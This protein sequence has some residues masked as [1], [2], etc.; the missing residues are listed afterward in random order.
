MT[1]AVPAALGPMMLSGL[2]WHPQPSSPPAPAHLLSSLGLDEAWPVILLPKDCSLH[3]REETARPYQISASCSKAQMAVKTY[4][5]YPELEGYP[6]V[7]PG[8]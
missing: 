4:Q 6:E 8:I 3:K 7:T 5:R 1:R 2:T